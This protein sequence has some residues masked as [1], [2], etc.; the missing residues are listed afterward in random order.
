MS[1]FDVVKSLVKDKESIYTTEG[2][3]S[4]E[5]NPFMINRILSNEQRT[6]LFADV[7]NQ[8]SC[9]DKKL[10]HD[11]YLYGI[12][13]FSGRIGYSKKDSSDDVDMECVE[14]IQV[15][16]KLSMQRAIEVL[17][18]LGVD[19]VKEEIASRGGRIVK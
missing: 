3:F 2:M 6:T 7:M 11:F 16:L 13:K 14:Y 15:K 18:L 5:Y 1:P 8:Y 4:K 9:I 10:Q 12:P 19:V 17:D